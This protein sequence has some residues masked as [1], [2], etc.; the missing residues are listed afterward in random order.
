MGRNQMSRSAWGGLVALGLLLARI[1]Y[2][3]LDAFD[4]AVPEWTV[5]LLLT[6]GLLVAMLG[7]TGMLGLLG[8]L[9][10]LGER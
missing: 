10:R 5:M 2:G 3:E 1:G 4:A 6:G 7:V 9:P 8:W